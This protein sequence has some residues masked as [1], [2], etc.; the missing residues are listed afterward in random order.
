M[1]AKKRIVRAGV[2]I[3]CECLE[4]VIRNRK[5]RKPRRW[6]VRPWIL[7]RRYEGASVKLLVEWARDDLDT[8]KNH[9]RMSEEKFEELL[10]KVSTS[11]QKKKTL[12]RDALP[13]RLKLQVTL[14]Y[15]ATGDSFPSLSAL[16]RVPKNSIS[17]FLPDVC[18]AIYHSLEDFIKV[19]VKIKYIFLTN[20]KVNIKY[21]N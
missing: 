16:Y 8:Y 5:K 15:L 14:K 4:N 12:L 18:K 7:R 20:K 17:Q 6:W 13:A 11:I 1:A 21:C 3:V 10:L 2:C 19:S 9:L